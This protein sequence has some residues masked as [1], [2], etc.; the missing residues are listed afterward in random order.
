MG[1]II[2]ID[3]SGVDEF[4]KKLKQSASNIVN[5]PVPVG[6]TVLITIGAMALVELI[7]FRNL[8]TTFVITRGR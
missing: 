5:H 6:K 4:K 3:L 1:T 2:S 7:V 8:K